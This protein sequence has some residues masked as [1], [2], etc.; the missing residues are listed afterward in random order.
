MPTPIIPEYITVHLGDPDQPARNVTVPFIDYI[1]NVA[2]SEIYPTWPESALRAN[3]LAQISFALNRIYTEWYRS[4][5]YDFDITSS[6]KFDQKFIE[7]RDFYDS[8]VRIVD[9]IFNNYVVKQGNIEPYFTQYCSGTTVTCDGLSQWGTVDLANQGLLPYQIL[10]YYYGDDINIIYNAPIQENVE[11]YPG[12]ILRL[13][14]SGEDVRIIQR[15]LNRISDNYPAIPKIPVTDGI[16]NV[17]TEEAVRKFQEIF[18]LTVDGI[19]GK[20]T[21][22][23]LKFIYTN[24]KRLG[25]LSSEGISIEEVRPIFVDVLR[26]GNVGTQVATMQ[27]YLAVIAYF[28]PLIPPVKIDGTFDQNTKDAVLAFQTKYGLEPTGE[29]DRE[30]WNKITEVYKTT[31]E[32]L[33][34]Q[35]I[36]ASEEIY[37]GRVLTMGIQGEDVSTLQRLLQRVSDNDP[38]I[39]RVEVTGT[40]DDA[41][42][43][44]I[45]QIQS[46]NS[47]PMSGA[48][49]ALT[50]NT[51]VNLSKQ[52]K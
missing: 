39:P 51:I 12:V 30:T 32:V 17:Q 38:S 50:W 2:S 5:G 9:N 4:R 31:S 44:A 52:A 42:A 34:S 25:E 7:N 27:Y 22:Y 28:D 37:P 40:F 33:K 18:N 43:N 48:V 24:V 46:Q 8:I 6:T 3:I 41:T 20:A 1:K 19:V 45:R 49:G 29:V 36:T 35:Y 16:F 21:W 47:L 14:D 23:K 15:Q 26:Q 10:R 13:G 11:S